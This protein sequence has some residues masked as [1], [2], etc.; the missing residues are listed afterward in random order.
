MGMNAQKMYYFKKIID[1][2][3]KE[4]YIKPIIIGHSSDDTGVVIKAF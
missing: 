2:V 4:N 1:L 3:K